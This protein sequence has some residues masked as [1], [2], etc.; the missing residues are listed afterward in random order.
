MIL[1]LGI[2][3]S[4]IVIAVCAGLGFGVVYTFWLLWKWLT[5]GSDA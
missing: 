4:L 2:V 1:G 5:Q 3:L